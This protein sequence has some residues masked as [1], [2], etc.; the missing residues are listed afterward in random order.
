MAEYKDHLW[1]TILTDANGACAWLCRDCT[2]IVQVRPM[3]K[4]APR[5]CGRMAWIPGPAYPDK[6]QM[7]FGE[8]QPVENTGKI[9]IS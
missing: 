8:S 3:Y 5:W 9:N 4:D 1:E 6:V 7:V 2:Q